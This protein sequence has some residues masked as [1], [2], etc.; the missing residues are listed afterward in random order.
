MRIS[1]IT[2]HKLGSKVDRPLHEG[3]VKQWFEDKGDQTL[4][5]EYDLDEHST[6]F[7]LGGYEGQ[8]SSD[9]Y[10]KYNCS[11]HIFEPVPIFAE[12]I[13]KRFAKNQKISVHQFGLAGATKSVRMAVNADGSSM[14]KLVGKAIYAHVVDVNTFLKENR[15][16]K[17]DLMKVNI[18]GAEYD[19]LEYIIESDC[20]RTITNLQVQFHSF[21]PDSGRRR[22]SIQGALERTHCLTY[23]YPFVWENW[24]IKNGN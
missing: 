1:A 11:I 13:K 10:S 9:I 19:L 3:V 21:V 18:E 16:N 8:W 15:I 6:V 14:F 4:R 7:D 22:K 20:I 12:K 17:I 5:L 23:E 2:L 24:H